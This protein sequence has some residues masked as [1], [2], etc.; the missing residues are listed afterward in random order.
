[1]HLRLSRLKYSRPRVWRTI[2][3]GAIL[4]VTMDYTLYSLGLYE[5]AM[6]AALSL[7]EK[8]D[9]A[10][11]NGFDFV[12]M[13]MDETEEKLARLETP[14]SWR[15]ALSGTMSDSGIPYSTMCLS[16][17]RKYPLGSADP[18]VSARGM[19][20]MRK[21]VILASD[22][23]IRIIQLA[24]YDVYYEPSSAETVARYGRNLAASVEFAARYG[25]ILAFETMETP[26]M[27]T[28]GKAL[29]WVDRIDSP[30]LKVYPDIGN[31]TNAFGGDAALAHADILAGK[32][33]IA[34]THLKET[35]PGIFREVPY[36]QGH[37]D[38]PACIDAAWSAGSRMFV[39][40]FWHLGSPDW[41][42]DLAAAN[43]FM[44]T[45]LD[46]RAALRASV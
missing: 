10:K 1:M 17:H 15:K 2:A 18:A 42:A 29:A 34:A 21:A 14:V 25:V 13:S 40:E 31:V 38:F 35:K 41:E 44:R 37:V 30:Y 5:K 9:A 4:P 16:G 45:R 3:P 28:V 33:R 32:G 8:L 27:N 11:R 46:A 26:F 39:A 24:G 6:P 20:I 22:L 7:G 36:G 23:G 43:R 19:D 12:E